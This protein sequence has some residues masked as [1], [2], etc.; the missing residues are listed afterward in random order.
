MIGTDE[1]MT[2]MDKWKTKVNELTEF[3]VSLAVGGGGCSDLGTACKSCGASTHG[4]SFACMTHHDECEAE[5]A[6][7]MTKV[8]HSLTARCKLCGLSLRYTPHGRGLDTCRAK[9]NPA[10]Y[11]AERTRRQRVHHKNKHNERKRESRAK[12]RMAGIPRCERDLS[13]ERVAQPRAARA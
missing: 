3:L 8:L 6:A 2:E 10:C 7:K 5:A 13:F 9:D 12:K 1:H 11:R 4:M